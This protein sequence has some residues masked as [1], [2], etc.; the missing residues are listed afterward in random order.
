MTMR[1]DLLDEVA[2]RYVNTNERKK[3]MLQTGNVDGADE[4]ISQLEDMRRCIEVR[5]L[6]RSWRE[7]GT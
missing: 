2:Y 6:S 4:A 3:R 7:G 5:E 1:D